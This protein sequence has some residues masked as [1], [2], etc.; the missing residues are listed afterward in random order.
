M[1][2]S[3]TNKITLNGKI[4]DRGSTNTGIG[5]VLSKESGLKTLFTG[6][7]AALFEVKCDSSVVF[8][9]SG[10]KVNSISTEASPD[11]LTKSMGYTVELE[12]TEKA[13]SEPPVISCSDSWNIEPVSDDYF[14]E[15][16][17]VPIQG[18]PEYNNP[19]LPGGAPSSSNT[20]TPATLNVNQIP[21]FKV[22]HKLMAKGVISSD[23]AACPVGSG[24][25]SPYI[26]AKKW[27]ENRLTAPW[28][29]TNVSGAYFGGTF[30]PTTM[31]D[32]VY[33]YNHVRSTNFSI[34][35]GTYE[36]NDTW[37]AM[38]TGIT[39]T[40]D[41]TIEVSTDEKY[42]KTVKVNGTIKG[43]SIQSANLVS[44]AG[45]LIPT[46]DGKMDFT[47]QNK[48]PQTA[49]NMTY[50]LDGAAGTTT[51][52][53][54]KY[55]NASIAWHSGIKPL[56]YRRACAGLNRPRYTASYVPLNY[57]RDKVLENPTYSQDNLLNIIPW[58]T[59]ESHDPRKGIIT[60]GYEFNNKFTIISGAIS[61]NISMD[62]TGP[63]DVVAEVFVL[64]RKLGPVL[65]SLSA[66]T[67]SKR[68]VSIDIT[69]MPATGISQYFMSNTNCPL[70]TGGNAYDT[71]EKIIEGLKPFGVRNSSVF[72]GA[73]RTTAP[74][75]QVYQTENQ[76]SWNP[77]EGKYT[78][79]ATWIYQQCNNDKFFLDT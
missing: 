65:Q 22:S 12:Y 1:L 16:F 23:L 69:V 9:A 21:Q 14:Y 63:N 73:G 77:T 8:S 49:T 72:I 44:D 62:D 38:P 76:F 30:S 78:R 45:Y 10:V 13:T 34:T 57:D 51:S 70:Y 31:G 37:L 48:T 33:L 2:L 52:Q 19:F 5:Y 17:T 64:G 53:S 56:V 24:Y 41:Y 55:Q 75:G 61:E 3:I 25:Y 68:S 7:P 66:K 20:I 50:T 29:S 42:I 79:K 15:F 27:V 59:S 36:I 54:Y 35:E 47:G 60:Y 67:T 6:C 11:F 28:Q 39:H 43:L 26:N 40:E 58:S 74:V 18:K 4:Y 32:S 71:I 46:G